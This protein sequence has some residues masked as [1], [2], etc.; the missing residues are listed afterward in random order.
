MRKQAGFTLIEL[1]IV[2][3]I[4]SILIV[5]MMN[6]FLAGIEERRV[7]T[8]V[9]EISDLFQAAQ[10]YAGNNSGTWPAE[11]GNCATAISTLSTATEGYLVGFNVKS[12]Y[13]N[14][15]GTVCPL[16][17]P[18]PRRFS[19]TLDTGDVGVAQQI[20]GILPSTTVTGTT[21]NTS[22]PLPAQIP[23]IANLLPRD[24]SQAMTGNLRLGSNNIEDVNQLKA[25]DVEISGT[26]LNG[27]N[28]K[29]S[30]GI[31]F[32]GIVGANSGLR[33]RKPI[34]PSGSPAIP[35]VVPAGNS[36]TVGTSAQANPIGAQYAWAQNIGGATG[37]WTFNY[38]M[39]IYKNNA[40][41]LNHRP[42]A[43]ANF[44]AVYMKCV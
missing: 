1:M 34:C 32:A 41:N 40:W 26:S 16:I 35:L 2:M 23:A 27:V 19:V 3:F 39:A 42:H 38:K 30:K 4:V 29:L 24:G 17:G 11:V 18:A 6:A 15:Y 14:N 10:L 43:R 31:H 33:Y 13:G 21:I 20:A 28:A 12:V 37:W 7:N 25:V 36:S 8:T 44:L 9:G 22:V 5:P